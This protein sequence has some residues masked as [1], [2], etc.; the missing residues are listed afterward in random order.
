[1][2]EQARSQAVQAIQWIV[3]FLIGGHAVSD[4]AHSLAS[5]TPATV[6]VNETA[7]PSSP[8]NGT[9]GGPV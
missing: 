6:V 2:S 4:A 7:R 3:G 9:S 1:L 8:P 5:R